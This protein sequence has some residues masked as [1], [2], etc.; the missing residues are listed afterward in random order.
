MKT[1]DISWVGVAAGV[2][3]DVL[4]GRAFWREARPLPSAMTPA[5]EP[6][7]DSPAWRRVMAMVEAAA[8]TDSTV[9]L[10]G[11]SG[12]GKELLARRI[13]R[14]SARAAGPFVP[15]NCAS[16]PKELWEREFF[17]PH[18]DAFTSAPSDWEGRFRFAHRGTL[19]LDD[20]EAMSG[21]GQAR[22]LR[23]IHDNEFGHLGDRQ[24][25]RVDQ[26]IIALTSCDLSTEVKKGRFRAD[27]YYR[28]NVAR[29]DVP[30]LRERV[31]DIGLLARL[32]AEEVSARLGRSA[33]EL[34]PETLS[35]LSAY[36]WPGNLHEL[37][38]VIERALVLDPAYG[39]HN[40]EPLP[41]PPVPAGADN[42]H[43]KGDLNLRGA[44]NRLE[45]E[46]L[47]EA[48]HRAGGVRKEA[49]RLLGIDPRNLAYYLRKH[50][51][52][53]GTQGG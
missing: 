28:L 11:E 43:A 38:S 42:G 19:L 29:I 14:L 23:V 4:G 7:G 17:G 50:G 6:V 18:N 5:T 15:L 45:R 46:L 34:R 10:L 32:C 40:L 13:H 26:R 30:P 35:R 44:L 33:P 41:A 20:V 12:T 36:S 24:P 9:L 39:L 31:D 2:V 16:I 1:A 3:L 8:R 37:R 49:A 25:R 47:L 27:L 22:L 21:M 53:E 48:H 51:L 52:V